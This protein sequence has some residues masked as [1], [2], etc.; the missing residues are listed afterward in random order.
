MGL[1]HLVAKIGLTPEQKKALELL[2]K[3]HKSFFKAM[4]EMVSKDED[5]TRANMMSPALGT[6]VLRRQIESEKKEKAEIQ[7]LIDQCRKLGIAEW[8]IKLST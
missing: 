5:F 6:E 7:Q 8:R 3:K 1:L 2:C 4:G